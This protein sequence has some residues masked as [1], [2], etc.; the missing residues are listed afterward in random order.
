MHA[1]KDEISNW[2]EKSNY[3]IF[4]SYVE[5]EFGYEL[6]DSISKKVIKNC[7]AMFMESQTTKEIDKVEKI[8]H[9]RKIIYCLML[10]QLAC[11]MLIH[12]LL[13]TMF[14]MV[15]HTYD[16]VKFPK[17]EKALE[18]MWI[19]RVKGK[20]N[21]KS[22]RYKTILGVQGSAIERVLKKDFIN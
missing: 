7:D 9:L 20:S 17:G 1:L 3:F 21:Y 13:L 22:L 12:I 14:K 15:S 11:L 8:L 5:D 18:N 6:Y 16:L 2:D 4:I 19:Y 10:I